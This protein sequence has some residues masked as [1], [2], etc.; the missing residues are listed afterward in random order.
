MNAVVT[1]VGRVIVRI[2]LDVS[3]MQALASVRKHGSEEFDYNAE[4]SLETLNGSA[5]VWD[6]AG[7]C[8]SV[9][10]LQVSGQPPAMK[11]DAA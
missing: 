4:F 2:E 6:E 8:L 3:R 11:A 1:E 10:P 9:V 7:Q 5:L